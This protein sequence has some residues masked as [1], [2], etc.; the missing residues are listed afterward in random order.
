MILQ[1]LLQLNESIAL[2]A[3]KHTFNEFTRAPQMQRWS[4]KDQPTQKGAA[5]EFAIR[6]WGT[7]QVPAGEED[8]G[9][10]DWQEPTPETDKAAEDIL[11]KCEKL[12]PN[13]KFHLT[14]GEKNWLYVQVEPK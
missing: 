13:V 10:Y 11:K 3:A 1:E 4:D 2:D 7:W 12:F 6:D 14:A 8:D 9:D 5:A